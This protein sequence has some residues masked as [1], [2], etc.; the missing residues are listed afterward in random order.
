MILAKGLCG[1]E[2]Y[3]RLSGHGATVS[4]ASGLHDLLGG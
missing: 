3:L 2:N 1:K 4:I